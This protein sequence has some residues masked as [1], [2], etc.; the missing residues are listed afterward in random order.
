[1]WKLYLKNGLPE[2][3]EYASPMLAKS[4]DGLPPAFVEVAEFDCLHDE[5]LAY[6]QALASAGIP[7]EIYESRQTIHGYEVAEKSEIVRA[8]ISRRVDA[9]NRAFRG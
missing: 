9:L 3:D 8:S 4:H 6:A 1:M 2:H 7:V 5:G